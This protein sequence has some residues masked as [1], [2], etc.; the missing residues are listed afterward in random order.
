MQQIMK[1]FFGGQGGGRIC[2][3]CAFLF[4]LFQKN[5]FEEEKELKWVIKE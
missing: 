1:E 5:C 2:V 3:E 4:Y